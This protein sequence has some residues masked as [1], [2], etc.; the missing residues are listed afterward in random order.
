MPSHTLVKNFI[1]KSPNHA[2]E[3]GIDIDKPS[4]YLDME[5]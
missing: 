5:I 3:S 1:L 2:L 4:Y